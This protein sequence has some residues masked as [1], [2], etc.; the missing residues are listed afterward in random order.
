MSTYFG[1]N[2]S[3]TLNSSNW[4]FSW[5]RFFMNDGNDRVITPNTGVA[6]EFRGG[7]GNDYFVGDTA[8]DRAYGG[9]H[10]DTLNGWSGNDILD[11]E[12]GNDT[13]LGGEGRDNLSGGTG[14]D[15]LYGGNGADDLFGGFNDRVS[16]YFH[17]SMGESQARV[18][19]ADTIYDWESA[20]DFI[21]TSI[22]GT[23]SNYAERATTATNIEAARSIVE[24]SASL[25]A[26]DHVFLYN[27]RTDTGYLLSDLNRNGTFET[28]VILKGAGSAL[29]FHYWDII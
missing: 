14:N 23:S 17:V 2:L 15:H 22:R 25:S 5:T 11:G 19:Q 7:N 8:N 16:D 13:L 10:N 29:D 9:N 3:E 6:Y 21:D 1:N 27:S 26:E 12:A 4:N 24:N 20:F 28:G 18:G